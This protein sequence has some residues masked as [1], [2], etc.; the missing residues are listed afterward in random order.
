MIWEE[1]GEPGRG[2]HKWREIIRALKEEGDRGS[3]IF[4]ELE[5]EEVRRALQSGHG[6]RDFQE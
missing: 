2:L 4:D 5:E 3:S 6:T 1:D